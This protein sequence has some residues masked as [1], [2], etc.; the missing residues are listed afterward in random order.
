[1]T[2]TPFKILLFLG[3]GEKSASD[4]KKHLKSIGIKQS[5]PSFYQM[6]GRMRRDDLVIQ[7]KKLGYNTAVSYYKATPKGK[8]AIKELQS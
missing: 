4:I 2:L 8:E 7:R 1:M 3:S 6:L 5:N